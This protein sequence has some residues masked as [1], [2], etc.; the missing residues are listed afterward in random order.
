MTPEGGPYIYAPRGALQS[1]LVQSRR[2]CNFY[3][4]KRRLVTIVFTVQV[5]QI[6]SLPMLCRMAK[7]RSTSCPHFSLVVCR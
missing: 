4:L 7:T 2:W 3:T 5:W 6:Y 1:T